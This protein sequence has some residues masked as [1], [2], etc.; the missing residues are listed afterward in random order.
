M[1]WPYLALLMRYLPENG[2]I[3]K[4]DTGERTALGGGRFGSSGSHD[5]G[6]IGSLISLLMRQADSLY[7]VPMSVGTSSGRIADPATDA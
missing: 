3:A 6:K 4:P 1:W 5:L 2:G 7:G